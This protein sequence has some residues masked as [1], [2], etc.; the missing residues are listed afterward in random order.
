MQ[1]RAALQP[2]AVALQMNPKERALYLKQKHTNVLLPD[3]E[4]TVASATS[5]SLRSFLRQARTF[6]AILTGH[7]AVCG[8]AGQV[9]PLHQQRWSSWTMRSLHVTS[10]TTLRVQMREELYQILGSF[11]SSVASF[12]QAAA[13][14]PAWV[15]ALVGDLDMLINSHLR[16]AMRHIYIPLI[17]A[18][19]P[20]YRQAPCTT[21]HW[22]RR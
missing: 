10:L 9:N 4:A 8:Q 15:A 20:I 5:A 2:V 12:Y 3:D 1:G 17:K 18:C 13:T 19:P 21:S 14:Q 6:Q 16:L 11:A 7:P 22:L